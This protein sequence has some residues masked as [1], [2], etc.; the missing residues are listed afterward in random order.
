MT[1][2][3]VLDVKATHQL[4]PKS[5]WRT[6]HCRNL[7]HLNVPTFGH[8]HNTNGQ[9]HGRISKNQRFL[10][11][12]DLYDMRRQNSSGSNSN[13]LSGTGRQGSHGAGGLLSGLV[14]CAKV[15]KSPFSA[16]ASES[17][18]TLSC[19]GKGEGG[20][21]GGEGGGE[22]GSG[23]ARAL[24]CRR[25]AGV[26]TGNPKIDFHSYK[27]AGQPWAPCV[28]QKP[29]MPSPSW[30]HFLVGMVPFWEGQG[31]EIS[32]REL[33]FEPLSWFGSPLFWGQKNIKV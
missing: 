8:V 12:K 21:G 24:T 6:L 1:A 25:Q 19:S 4:T 22:G 9:S 2:D 7:P 3:R 5:K 28:S 18:S 20:G 11:K 13:G 15:A 29:G 16:L 23:R 32:M 27:V 33:I 14:N 10:C 31:F 26:T 30:A 17:N